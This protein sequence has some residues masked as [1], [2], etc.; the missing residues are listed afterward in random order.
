[1]KIR[2]TENAR[3][4]LDRVHAFYAEFDRRLAARMFRSIKESTR[5]LARFPA[6]GRIGEVAGTRE[7]VVP[8]LPFVVVYRLEDNEIQ[9]L[10]VFHDS[11]DWQRLM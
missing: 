7:L 11:Q 3:L 8:H 2:W 5:R 9:V 1:M 6:S 10:R 4:G